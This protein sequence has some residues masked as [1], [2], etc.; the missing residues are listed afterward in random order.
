MAPERDTQRDDEDRN[1]R[2]SPVGVHLH[3][4]TVLGV[5][6]HDPRLHTEL[7]RFVPNDADALYPL[8]IPPTE[9]NTRSVVLAAAYNPP[10]TGAALAFRG[11]RTVRGPSLQSA[12]AINSIA[13]NRDLP[14]RPLS[15]DGF[16]QVPRQ[17]LLWTLTA[18]LLTAL[19][20]VTAVVFIGA[21]IGPSTVV[22]AGVV[23]ALTASFVLAHAGAHLGLRDEAIFERVRETA[24]R[25]DDNHPVV[26]VPERHVPGIAAD[27]KDNQIKTTD[28]AVSTE[29]TADESLY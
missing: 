28:R 22:L 12:A 26:V 21:G 4:L 14:V 10:A 29:L 5:D 6:G 19:L 11:V 18:W 17:G 24:A 1:R 20:A 27:A 23:T 16:E 3:R 8:A 25:C 2:C 9:L 13:E 15:A 7:H